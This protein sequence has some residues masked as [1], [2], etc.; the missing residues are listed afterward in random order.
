MENATKPRPL[1]I[2]QPDIPRHRRRNGRAMV[3][4]CTRCHN[5]PIEFIYR[6]NWTDH[7]YCPQCDLEH[8]ADIRQK[9]ELIDSNERQIERYGE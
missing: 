5:G 3:M 9:T 8:M 4:K 2:T 7:H 1:E 6:I